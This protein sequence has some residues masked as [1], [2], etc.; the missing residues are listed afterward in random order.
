M[1]NMQA[2]RKNKRNYPVKKRMGFFPP[3]ELWGNKPGDYRHETDTALL[4]LPIRIFQEKY[5][6]TEDIYCLD[7]LSM[8]Y[9]QKQMNS[10][11]D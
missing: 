1:T 5:L 3:G 11:T 6:Q 8:H 4:A 2:Y 10:V 9:K 7:G